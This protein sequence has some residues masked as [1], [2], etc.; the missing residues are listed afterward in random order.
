LVSI[1]LGTFTILGSVD[2]YEG[3]SSNAVTWN[4]TLNGSCTAFD[5]VPIFI[6]VIAG[7]LILCIMAT[8]RAF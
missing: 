2:N 7:A 4:A 5:V 3:A 8:T 1:P 6:V